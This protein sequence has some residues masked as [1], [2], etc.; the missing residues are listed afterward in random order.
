[1]PYQVVA[2]TEG[3]G[4]GGGPRVEFSD[5]GG[6]VFLIVGAYNGLNNIVNNGRQLVIQ[7]NGGL[8]ITGLTTPPAGTPTRDL[9]VDADGNIYVQS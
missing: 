4:T 9:V 6:V 5:D 3:A 7:L 1:M 8:K 2:K